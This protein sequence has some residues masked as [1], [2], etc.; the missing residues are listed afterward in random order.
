MVQLIDNKVCRTLGWYATI[1]LPACRVGLFHV[2][3]STTTTIA[4]YR[5]GK[6][7]RCL[8]TS[9]VECIELTFEVSLH[10]CRPGVI[11]IGHKFHF[12][13]GFST[14]SC[15]IK[16]ER[17]LRGS[18]EAESR[19]T[20]RIGHLVESLLCCNVLREYESSNRC[21]KFIFYFHW[22]LNVRCWV[23]NDG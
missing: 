3:N 17:W 14:S 6:D 21:C 11:A 1:A 5:F 9:D 12:L 10:G 13:I 22:V 18:V 7:T 16:A 15:L 20:W 19:L 8:T 4:A 2:D 23:L